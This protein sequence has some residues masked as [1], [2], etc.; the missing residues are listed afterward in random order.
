MREPPEISRTIDAL[1]R[2]LGEDMIF[3][4]RVDARDEA[5]ELLKLFILMDYVSLYVA[6]LRGVDPLSAPRMSRLKRLNPVYGEVIEEVERR[7]AGR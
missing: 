3:S 7:V 5:E 6:V 1:S 4:I 2:L